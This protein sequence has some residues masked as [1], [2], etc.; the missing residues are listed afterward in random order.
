[1]IFILIH[2]NVFLIK[3]II[4]IKS[5][6]TTITNNNNVSNNY[7]TSPLLNTIFK[8]KKR[9]SKTIKYNKTDRH[10]I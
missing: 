3:Y 4:I 2:N 1:M 5:S 10:K 9:H 7:R 6:V 8:I